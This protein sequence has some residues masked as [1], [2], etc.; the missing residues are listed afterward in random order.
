MRISP[1]NTC[2]AGSVSSGALQGF[3]SFLA[4]GARAD[5]VPDENQDD[6]NDEDQC[7]DGVDFRR[8]AAPEARPNFERESIV[9]ADEEER[10]GDFIHGESEDEQSGGDERESQTGERDAPESLERCGAKGERGLVLGAVHF[11]ESGEEFGGGHRNERGAVAE[12]NGKE[13][14]LKSREDGEH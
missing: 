3:F 5:V 11:L 8:D 14:E 7:G 13:A 2:P 12:E 1:P 10:N 4:E 9:A 6:G